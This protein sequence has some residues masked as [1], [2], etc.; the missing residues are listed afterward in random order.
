MLTFSFTDTVLSIVS[1]CAGIKLIQRV[2]D[3]VSHSGLSVTGSRHRN[4]LVDNTAQN[5]GIVIVN[6]SSL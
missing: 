5:T 2:N 6:S 3:E 4:K 1:E